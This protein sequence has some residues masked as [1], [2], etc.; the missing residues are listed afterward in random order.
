MSNKIK[1]LSDSPIDLVERGSTGTIDDT[2][3]IDQRL[4]VFLNI[5]EVFVNNSV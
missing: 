1:P 3:T 2:K 4:Y 5:F